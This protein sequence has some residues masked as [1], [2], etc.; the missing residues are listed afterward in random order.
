M[1]FMGLQP[2]RSYVSNV[3]VAAD[4]VF[5]R[6]CS[7]TGNA[8]KD[9]TVCKLL[10]ECCQQMAEVFQWDLTRAANACLNSIGITSVHHRTT[11]NL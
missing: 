7:G 2:E 8:V 6:G 9:P 11:P 1:P 10:G 4:I 5:A 3:P